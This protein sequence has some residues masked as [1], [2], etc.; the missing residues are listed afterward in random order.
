MVHNLGL[1]M[2]FEMQLLALLISLGILYDGPLW[3]PEAIKQT[4][5]SMYF[6]FLLD[7]ILARPDSIPNRHPA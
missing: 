1:E 6:E 4:V 5:Y 7:S 3:E 2:P